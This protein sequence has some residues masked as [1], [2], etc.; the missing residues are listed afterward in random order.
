MFLALWIVAGLG[1][2]GIALFVD[3]TAVR[4][5]L[6]LGGLALLA[7]LAFRAG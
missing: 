6:F 5:T 7:T 4:V 1:L 3:R 2:M